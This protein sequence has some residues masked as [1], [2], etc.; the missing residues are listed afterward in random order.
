MPGHI[1]IVN[2]ERETEKFMFT[3]TYIYLSEPD[4]FHKQN[5]VDKR[6]EEVETPLPRGGHRRA[7]GPLLKTRKP[8][9]ITMLAN[10]GCNH[11]DHNRVF[12]CQLS[13]VTPPL[14]TT[15]PGPGEWRRF[16]TKH[17]RTIA[18]TIIM[19]KTGNMGRTAWVAVSLGNLEQDRIMIRLRS[20][21]GPLWR[22]IMIVTEVNSQWEQV[23]FHKVCAPE[24]W[25]TKK[26]ST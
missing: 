21:S 4:T 7:A 14:A 19:T 18:V 2:R 1:C 20:G 13:Q 17:Y 26:E 3:I 12:S 6:C 15:P 9:Q 16:K 23:R 5:A 10:I 24:Y 8:R 11:S 22:K 25:C